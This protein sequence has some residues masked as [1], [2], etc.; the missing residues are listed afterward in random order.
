MHEKLLPF[1]GISLSEISL[2]LLWI[3]MPM[4]LFFSLQ[5]A[6]NDDK[7]KLISVKSSC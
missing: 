7:L 6:Q 4:V 2:Y 3:Q 1:R 5:K